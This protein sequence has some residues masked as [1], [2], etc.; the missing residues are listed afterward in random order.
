VGGEGGGGGVPGPLGPDGVPGGG[1]GVPGGGGGVPGVPG[2][3]GE[4]LLD[5]MAGEDEAGLD[6]TTGVEDATTGLDEAALLAGADVTP[7]A[8]EDADAP[9][10]A[11]EEA[12]GLAEDRPQFPKPF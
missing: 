4:G 3:G 12:A 6:E 1:G 10:E 11:A 2:P 5:E 9:V 8:E 7:A